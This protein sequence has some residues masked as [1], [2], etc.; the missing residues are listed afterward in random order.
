MWKEQQYY[1]I[2][3]ML[4]ISGTIGRFTSLNPIEVVSCSISCL[5]VYFVVTDLRL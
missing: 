4:S 1:V 2:A 5:F 3:K